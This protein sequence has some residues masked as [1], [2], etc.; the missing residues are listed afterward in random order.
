MPRDSHRFLATIYKIWIMR[1]V[2]VPEDIASA[3]IREMRRAD[4]TAARKVK[5]AEGAVPKHIPVVATVNRVSVQTT[6]VPAGDGKYRLAVNTEL[7]KAGGA[8][9]GDVIG[10]ELR[11][12]PDSRHVDVPAEYAAGMARNAVARKEFE[13]LPPGHKRQ[14]AR[15]Y[16]KAK[17]EGARSRAIEKTIEHL[18]ER[19]LLRP[20]AKKSKPSA[21]RKSSKRKTS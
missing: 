11:F 16:L 3:L 10:V 8:D 4:R 21:E 18:R 14:L 12:D 13:R 20:P 7:R 2:S 17:S 1:H 15:F 9:T 6:L 19:A 5:G